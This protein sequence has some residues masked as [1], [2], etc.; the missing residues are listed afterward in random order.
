MSDDWFQQRGIRRTEEVSVI[1]TP[2]LRQEQDHNC[3][4]TAALV[5][6]RSVGLDGTGD[7][8][9]PVVGTSPETLVAMLLRGGACVGP[10]TWTVAD[11]QHFTK[12]GRPV[13]CPVATF[14]GHWVVVRG[15]GRGKVHYHCPSF[16]RE[17]V[18]FAKWADLWKDLSMS[19]ATYRNW[20]IV[21]SNRS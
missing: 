21:V 10:G 7:L 15:V 16:G 19:G 5:A 2:D 1:D 11:L 17:S 18:S 8:S 6:L 3:G 14:G 4:H 12:S 9:H 20:G 13:V